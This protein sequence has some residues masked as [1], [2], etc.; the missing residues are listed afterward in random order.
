MAAA[1]SKVTVQITVKAGD[2]NVALAKTLTL[3]EFEFGTE[4]KQAQDLL[5]DLASAADENLA[6]AAKLDNVRKTLTAVGDD[7]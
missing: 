3:E 7:D 5:I 1:T 6:R 2:T 4:I